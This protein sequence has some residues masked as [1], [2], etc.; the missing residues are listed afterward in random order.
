MK[1]KPRKQHGH[2]RKPSVSTRVWP[3]PLSC[4]TNL[5]SIPVDRQV[6]VAP[7]VDRHTL[8]TEIDNG[9]DTSTAPRAT[10][11][12]HALT[13]TALDTTR[14]SSPG[15]TVSP[16]L[17][18]QGQPPSAQSALACGHWQDVDPGTTVAPVGSIPSVRS[19]RGRRTP[20]KQSNPARWTPLSRPKRSRPPRAASV[21][22]SP[23]RK[24]LC[25]AR[26]TSHPP[27][28]LWQPAFRRD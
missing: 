3:S 11:I 7:V 18:R 4:T 28:T 8:I 5:P 21:S 14:L 19:T 22:A 25:T 20:R 12:D 27:R 17:L 2:T 23:V 10:S 15:S 24:R 9:N 16:V 26:S 13:S 6:T 1:D